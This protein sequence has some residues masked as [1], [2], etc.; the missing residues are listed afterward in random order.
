MKTLFLL[1]WTFC[2]AYQDIN[3][4]RPEDVSISGMQLGISMKDFKR[5]IG[6]PDSVVKEVN[7][8]HGFEYLVTYRNASSY[9]FSDDKLDGFHLKDKGSFI[10]IKN[11]KIQIGD[12]QGVLKE[13]FPL[14]YKAKYKSSKDVEIVKVRF[15][16]SDDYLLFKIVDNKIHSMLSW[17]DW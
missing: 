9:T 5:K 17:T 3:E 13:L 16:N 11:R 6:E 7:E 2:V 8:F 4:V 15:G 10:S 1:V 12:Q 14:S